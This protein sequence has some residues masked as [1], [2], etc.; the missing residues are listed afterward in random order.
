MQGRSRN[1][2]SDAEVKAALQGRTGSRTL[3]FRYDLLDKSNVYQR[4][5]DNVM[6]GTVLLN[7]LAEIKRV[8]RLVVTDTGVVNYL[9][10]RIKPWVRL[11]MPARSESYADV[12]ATVPGPL[13]RWKLD[14]VS[15]TVA[16]DASG[17]G[18]TGTIPASGVTKGK[19]GLLNG[20]SSFLFTAGNTGVVAS[21]AGWVDG[22][23]ALTMVA[24]FRSDEV[25]VTKS[26]LGGS[27]V[28]LSYQAAGE[29]GGAASCVQARVNTDHGPAIACTVAGTQSRGLQCIVA[30][31]QAGQGI[32]IYLNGEEAQLSGTTP[33]LAAGVS[34][35]AFGT[36]K[37][38][39]DCNG[40]VDDASLFAGVAT[41][42]QARAIYQAGLAVGPY[43]TE[44][45]V[46][47]PQGV[48]L[49]SSPKRKRT[50]AGVVVREVEGYD[51]LLVYA[52]D[53]VAD[54][55]VAPAGALYTEVIR[56]LMADTPQK[57]I[58]NSPLTLPTAREWEPGTSKLRIINDLLSAIN[59]RSLS[60][61]EDG[62]GIVAPYTSPQ[63]RP[64]EYDY[65]DDE[66]SVIS[67]EME[68]ELD[69]FAVPNK[70]VLVVSDPDRPALV[71][72]YVNA[73]PL[74]LTSTVSRGRTITDVRNEQDAA[75]QSTLDGKARRLAFE[76]SQVY[77]TVDFTTA[78]MPIH[79]TDD[80]Y[81][82]TYSGLAIS[83]KY[84][85]HSWEL[86][87]EAGALMKHSAR[88]VVQV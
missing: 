61:D 25:G 67:P 36:F 60:F 64:A 80:V 58:S 68:Q 9:S 10:D 83:A 78:I 42:D 18:R 62:V 37:V 59:Y 40:T 7:N 12:L 79:S 56:T 13:V 55:Y 27:T 69:V 22:H 76:A 71:G 73:D 74:S 33:P 72:T 50:R 24:W 15:G 43:G 6:S 66:T 52:D 20:G 77:E 26:I 51:Q 65:A 23:D 44:N 17:N 47:W 70:W 84:S 5:L 4:P 75:D 53:K 81:N 16:A 57:S 19:P 38:G 28:S 34:A 21:P 35:S 1:G 48:F 41:S 29:V 11:A 3:T 49:L 39:E 14:E 46:E 87:L 88:R 85:E 82:L 32:H 45:W 31:W 8:I 86:P 2:Y 63:D 54:R 30:V